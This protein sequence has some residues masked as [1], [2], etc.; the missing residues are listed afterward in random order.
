MLLGYALS[1]W[2]LG[3]F[4][5]APQVLVLAQSLLHVMLWASVVFGMQAVV[6][7]VM[8]ASGTVWGPTGIS[9]ASIA[10]VQLPAAHWLS[11]RFGLQGV[12][13]SYPVLFTTMLCLQ[14]AF[15]HLVWRTRRIERLV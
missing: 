12:W 8:R 15:Y 14:T 4:I 1:H 9:V 7:G 3:F 2:L 10:L 13:M 11:A 6:A 5:T